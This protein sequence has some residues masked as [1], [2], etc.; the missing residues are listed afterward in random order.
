LLGG[1]ATAQAPLN[2]NTLP[3]VVRSSLQS[4]AANGTL[5]TVSQQTTANG[6]V[7]TATVTQNGTPMQLQIA[8]NG[9]IISQS[10]ITG[11]PSVAGVTGNAASVG[12]MSGAAAGLPLSTLPANL[13]QSILST[14]G[15]AAGIQTIS[16]DQ[17]AN[18]T[19]YR[20]TALRNGVPTEFRFGANG[21][22][23]GTAPISG[24]ATSAFTPDGVGVAGAGGVV[25]GALPV[26]LQRAIRTAAGNGQITGITQQQST[27][28]MSYLVNYDQN[29][30]PM[31]MAIAADG[32][33]LSNTPMTGIGGA[34][35]A[36]TGTG[37]N[38]S[39]STNKTSSLK[40]DDL[41]DAVRTTL[42]NQAPNADIHFINHEQRPGGD[43]YIVGLRT[44]DRFAQLEINS[45][46]TVTYDSRT[47]PVIAIGQQTSDQ[48]DQSMEFASLP[49]AIKN[50]VNAYATAGNVRN[51]TL[52]TD[53]DGKTVY[54]VV[55]YNDGRRDRMIVSKEGKLV[56]ID[57]NIA[58][59][60]AI[61]LSDKAPLIAIG[62]LPQAVQDTIRRETDNVRVEK[63]DTKLVGDETVYAVDYK[64]NGAPVELLVSTEGTVVY[65]IGGLGAPSKEE[66]QPAPL[67]GSEREP[68]RTVDAT[69]INADSA[70]T[71]T[72]RITASSSSGTSAA[73]EQGSSAAT[74]S[75]ASK[76]KQKVRL[77]DVPVAVQSAA[78]KLAGEGVIISI[79]PKLENSSVLYEVTYTQDGNK[80]TTDVNKDGVVKN[81]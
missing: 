65:P 14:V 16:R 23:L 31:R 71:A 21:T 50:A 26:N 41:P 40:L 11:S 73:A 24:A 22:L 59:A 70:P 4:Y 29:G 75:A 66:P 42:K 2:V 48:N 43:T 61:G 54:N 28:G 60:A 52:G 6:P 36:V 55:Y 57:R 39:A 63:I 77:N 74:N 38:A 76:S 49:A 67:T 46:G 8:A 13:Q 81:K 37:T 15:G 27:N 33:V 3:P 62:D 1:G 58:P 7:Y 9:R 17:L 10:P 51:V 53:K 80:K 64:T 30:R 18:G 32:R 45:K 56:R 5:G 68:V 79:N 47:V 78:K 44:R 19:F 25:L 72:S 69:A 20:I 35:T 34:A 12:T